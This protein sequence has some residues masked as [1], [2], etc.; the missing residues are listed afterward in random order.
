M[1][2][3]ICIEDEEYMKEKSSAPT[4]F[5]KKVAAMLAKQKGKKAPD[6]HDFEKAKELEEED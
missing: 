5:Q 4:A 2:I 1:K 6:E 3:E